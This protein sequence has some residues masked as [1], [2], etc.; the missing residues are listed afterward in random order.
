M[1][2]KLLKPLWGHKKGDKIEIAEDKIDFAVRK[3][4]IKIDKVETKNKMIDTEI[5]NKKI[6]SK[7]AKVIVKKQNFVGHKDI[8]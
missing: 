3:G 2:H 5:S 1:K 7:K 8:K 6:E 4:F